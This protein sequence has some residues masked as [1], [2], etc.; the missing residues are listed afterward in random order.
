MQFTSFLL[1]SACSLRQL[2]LTW[3][4]ISEADLIE[5]L[6]HLPALTDLS[7]SPG[8]TRLAGD[9]WRRLTYRHEEDCLCPKLQSI[10][11]YLMQYRYFNLNAYADMVQSRWM[12][13]FESDIEKRISC[14]REFDL[15]FIR[16][17]VGYNRVMIS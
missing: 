7:Y 15:E 5:F 3:V 2:T 17:V 9:I 6:Q 16:E 1:R 11:F 13:D 12:L 4:W 10:S 14:L 8:V